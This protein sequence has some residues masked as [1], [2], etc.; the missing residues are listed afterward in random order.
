LIVWNLLSWCRNTWSSISCFGTG[1]TA[2]VDEPAPQVHLPR[3]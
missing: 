2:A 3:D 1:G